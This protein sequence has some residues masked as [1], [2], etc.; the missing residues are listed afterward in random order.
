VLVGGACV[1]VGVSATALGV[2]VGVGVP[3]A[4]AVRVGVILGADVDQVAVHG[5]IVL[6]MVGVFVPV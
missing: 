2:A 4:V 3:D 6:V 1:G 5:I